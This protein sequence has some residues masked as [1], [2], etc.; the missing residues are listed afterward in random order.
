MMNCESLG[1]NC[2]LG[3]VQRKAGVEPIG[4]FRFAAVHSVQLIQLLETELAELGNPEFTYIEQE[5][6]SSE[7]FRRDRRNLYMMHSLFK[8]SA[9]DNNKFFEQQLRRLAFLKR[10]LMEDLTAAEK[11]FVYKSTDKNILDEDLVKIHAAIKRYGDNVLL[12]VRL[13]TD[14][15]PAGSTFALGRNL[16]VGH[17]GWMYGN[18]GD[19]KPLDYGSWFKIVNKR[20]PLAY[21]PPEWKTL[22]DPLSFP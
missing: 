2:E 13:A 10:K 17:V 4:L 6:T 21:A 8:P 9:V 7:Y 1:D 3:S 16:I 14:R 12:G 15:C 22:H 19:I 5:K 18:G 11:L 20:A